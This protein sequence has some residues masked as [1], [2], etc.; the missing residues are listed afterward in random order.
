[1]EV[2]DLV[3][4]NAFLF[5]RIDGGDNDFSTLEESLDALLYSASSAICSGDDISVDKEQHPHHHQHPHPPAPHYQHPHQEQQQQQQQ[6]QQQQNQQ[7]P[8][9]VVGGGMAATTTTVISPN[10]VD[11]RT[12]SNDMNLNGNGNRNSHG[13]VNYRWS[14]NRA[15]E[16][17]ASYE[18]NNMN[19]NAVHMEVQENA[20]IPNLYNMPQR[21]QPR[22]EAVAG[23]R[24]RN[25][26]ID[27]NSGGIG[28]GPGGP[29]L[30]DEIMRLDEVDW[31]LTEKFLMS[32]NRCV[33]IFVCVF[34]T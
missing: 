17:M 15:L 24:S 12:S 4:D 26:S 20:K 34:L 23:D 2:D 30:L 25:A 13:D 16:P 14:G 27:I 18:M 3:G 5:D 19:M 6:N 11:V 21:R 32:E 9:V 22:S 29:G 1:M 33:C 10:E 8:R 7:Q 31:N 28:N